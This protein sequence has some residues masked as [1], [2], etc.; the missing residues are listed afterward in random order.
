MNLNNLSNLKWEIFR[1]QDYQYRAFA[2]V[3]KIPSAP[4]PKAPAASNPNPPAYSPPI[5]PAYSPPNPP[6]YSPPSNSPSK[7][8]PGSGSNPPSNSS[9]GSPS[10][11]SRSPPA[12]GAASS[13]STLSNGRPYIVGGGLPSSRAPAIGAG[14]L[15]GSGVYY[16]GSRRSI[17]RNSCTCECINSNATMI[18]N[19]TIDQDGDVDLGNNTDSIRGFVVCY[20]I[21]VNNDFDPCKSE[22]PYLPETSSAKKIK[23]NLFLII[24]FILSLIQT[25]VM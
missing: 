7:P 15:I 22:C 11:G 2:K 1:R 21:E 9:P 25:S 24:L 13:S 6:P 17:N 20:G 5:L 16:L 19:K 18:I 3:P 14:L 8:I 12:G 23:Y 10:T 4:K